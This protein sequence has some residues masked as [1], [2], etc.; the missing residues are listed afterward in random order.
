MS[1]PLENLSL[2]D[3]LRVDR[4]TLRLI[5]LFAGL[6]LYGISLALIIRAGLGVDPWD[7]L[8]I[9]LAERTGLSIGVVVILVSVLLLLAWVPLRRQV[10][11]G[12]LANAVWIGVVTDIALVRVPEAAG[13][14]AGIVMLGLGVVTNA[15]ATA[16]YVGTQLG[17]GPRDGLMTGLHDLTGLPI[18]LVRCAIE[19]A[20]V[21][22]GWLLGG[23]VGIGTLVYAVAIGPL[24]QHMLPWVTI[25]VREPALTD[26]R[27]R[28]PA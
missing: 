7:V 16:I 23:P 10:G 2:R 27:P 26:R 12:T 24:V 25:P 19:I 21:V 6:T 22:L 5:A 4:R 11:I 9:A 17:P 14:T 15:L 28:R 18:G 1:T 3:Q 20:V 13:I 8:Q